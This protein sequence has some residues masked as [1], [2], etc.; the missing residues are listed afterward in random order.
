M[1]FHWGVGYEH[2]GIEHMLEFLDMG[3]RSG[4][5]VDALDAQTKQFDSL[6]TLIHNQGHSKAIT[7]I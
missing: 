7:L 5:S 3:H 6:D 1:A 4:L 2:T